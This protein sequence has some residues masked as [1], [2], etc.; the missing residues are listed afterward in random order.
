MDRLADIFAVIC[1][2][3]C[4]VNMVLLF[5]D[6]I[7]RY[8]LKTSLPGATEYATVILM[9]VAYFG[10]SYTHKLGRH[11][12]MGALYEKFHPGMKA[13][14]DIIINLIILFVFA[15][16]I[17]TT[18]S[19]FLRSVETME[20]MQASVPVYRWP[21]RLAIVLGCAAFWLRTVVTFVDSV[22]VAVKI[23][24]DATAWANK[25]TSREGE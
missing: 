19:S 6:I 8:A 18:W 25:P 13:I 3:A 10:I 14:V 12:E 11:M 16:F 1:A 2:A 4:L 22:V 5:V 17:I 23:T 24:K 7:L 9:F 21:G 15:V 20:T